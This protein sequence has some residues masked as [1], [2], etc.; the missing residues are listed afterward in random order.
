MPTEISPL[1][2]VPAAAGG[3]IA[4]VVAVATPAAGSVEWGATQRKE[5]GALFNL[6]KIDD[7][8]VKREAVEKSLWWWNLTCG[9]FHLVQGIVALIL[10]E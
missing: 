8:P 6:S 4:A 5:G 3:D 7:D 9:V 2:N 1:K 10:G